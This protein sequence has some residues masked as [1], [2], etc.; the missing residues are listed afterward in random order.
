MAPVS[1]RVAL[2]LLARASIMN[3]MRKQCTPLLLLLAEIFSRVSASARILELR[4]S[5]SSLGFQGFPLGSTGSPA[6]VRRQL[7]WFSAAVV[8]FI[9]R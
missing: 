9:R 1:T 6:A 4:H 7:G 2:Q 8:G 3:A 5:S